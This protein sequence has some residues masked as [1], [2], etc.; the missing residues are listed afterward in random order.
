M[1]II[2]YYLP[3]GLLLRV[4]SG[5]YVFMILF[6]RYYFVIINKFI[7]YQYIAL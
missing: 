6:H 1:N 5:L 7:H 4:R 2:Y 3:F